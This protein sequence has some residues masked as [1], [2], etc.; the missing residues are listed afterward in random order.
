MG[1][2][3]HLN[4]SIRYIMNPKKQRKENGLA[5]MPGWLQM[6]YIKR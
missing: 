6:K 4:N 2:G 1:G 5:E 3:R